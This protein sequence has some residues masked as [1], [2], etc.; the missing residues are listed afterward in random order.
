[1]YYRPAG[2]DAVSGAVIESADYNLNVGDVE[3]DLN[4]PRPIVAGGTGATTATDALDN[5]GAEAAH[6]YV[7]NFDSFAFRSGSFYSDGTTTGAPQPPPNSTIWGVSVV[8]DNDP[9]YIILRGY[10]RAGNLYT[11]QRDAGTWGAWTNQTATI[12]GKVNKT[13]DTMTGTLT[14]NVAGTALDV[15]NGNI[16]V[17]PNSSIFNTT[18]SLQIGPGNG[19]LYLRTAAGAAISV[20]DTGGTV[21]LGSASYDTYV[22]KGL[23]VNTNISFDSGPEIQSSGASLLLYGN[24][25]LIR[26]QSASAITIGDINANAVNIGRTGINTTV[27]GTLIDGTGRIIS[28]DST[29]PSLCCYNPGVGVAGGLFV[30]GTSNLLLGPMDAN[31]APTTYKSYWNFTS[32]QFVHTGSAYKPSGGP[33]TDTSDARI[34]TVIGDYTHGLAEIETLQPV[35]YSFRGNDTPEPHSRKEPSPYPESTHYQVA[36]DGI[37]YIGLIAQDCAALPEMVTATKGNIDGIPVDDLLTLDTGA[38]IFALV[39]AVKE[40]SARVKTLEGT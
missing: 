3:T 36:K 32:N 30:D 10:D 5:L 1:M 33:W 37:Q 15:T 23:H 19:N 16:R 22:K 9:N 24:G 28:R 8:Y 39:N 40:L 25:V 35:L 20:G 11:R 2:I 27:T 21:N 38:L 6:Q 26:T 7:G 31:G 12:N 4:T 18:G 29:N 17:A 34:K 13:G 14:L